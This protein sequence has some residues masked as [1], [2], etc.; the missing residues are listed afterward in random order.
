VLTGAV[1]YPGDIW[2]HVRARTVL[3][4]RAAGIE[5]IDGPFPNFRDPDGY[6]EEARRARA[7]GFAGKWAIHPSQIALANEV[8][9]PSDDEVCAARGVVEAY[10]EAERAGSGAAGH[11]G[12]LIDAAAVRMM[13]GTLAKAELIARRLG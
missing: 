4:A 13:E 11:G 7:L 10:R 3:A 9:S 6:Q 1:A 8:F 5:A 12:S 2:H